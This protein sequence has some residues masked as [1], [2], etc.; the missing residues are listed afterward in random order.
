RRA[1]SRAPTGA[2]LRRAPAPPPP[3]PPPT[4]PCEGPPPAVMHSGL[5]GEIGRGGMGAVYRAR[6]SRLN[7][8]VALKVLTAASQADP[9]HLARFRLE[10][11]AAARLQHPGIVQLFEFGE[12]HGRPFLV[13]ELV[14]GGPPPA[15]LDGRPWPPRRAAA[16][17]EAL[18]RAVHYAHS[19]GIVHRDLKPGNVLLAEDGTPKVTDFGLAKFTESDDSR[20]QIGEVLG[21]PDYMAP[22]QAAGGASGSIGPAADVWALGAI[23]YECL[24][25]QA[26]FSGEDPVEIVLKVRTEEP[27][28]PA[29][30]NP[31]VPR[32]LETVCLKCLEKEPER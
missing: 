29:S 26:P 4:V 25:G 15:R 9:D 19:R 17:V 13:L 12:H 8:T 6:D 23:L 14:P 31:A 11:D 7:R 30:L 27:P 22:E 10:A 21:T 18:A 2:P 1:A 5:L 28:A 32:D 24:T 20:T 16:L 3:A